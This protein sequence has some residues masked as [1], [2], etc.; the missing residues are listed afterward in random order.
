MQA[1]LRRTPRLPGFFKDYNEYVDLV[2]LDSLRC[3]AYNLLTV[4]W[5]HEDCC[6]DLYYLTT[7]PTGS[8]VLDSVRIA[9]RGLDGQ[10]HA[11]ALMRPT[12]NG[13]LLVT[14]REENDSDAQN[15]PNVLDSVVT[16]YAV[17]PQGR[18]VTKQLSR[19]Q[20][21]LRPKEHIPSAHEQ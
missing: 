15:E 17:T 19:G 11:E 16:A 20:R 13:E 18:F 12:G 7:S 10:W 8:A 3:P 9:A 1:M 6:E 21:N 2:L 14:A 4:L 5:R